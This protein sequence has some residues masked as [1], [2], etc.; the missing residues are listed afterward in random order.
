M[1]QKAWWIYFEIS[2]AILECL[3]VALPFTVIVTVQ[4]AKKHKIAM[5]MLFSY[6][7]A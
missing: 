1:A 7:L 6:R 5:L 4:A 3:L 2:N